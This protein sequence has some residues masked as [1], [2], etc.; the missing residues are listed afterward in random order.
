M[1]VVGSSPGRPMRRGKRPHS[2]QASADRLQ[3]SPPTDRQLG[4]PGGGRGQVSAVTAARAAATR[5]PPD[6]S[7]RRH[8]GQRARA[9]AGRREASEPEEN[10][11]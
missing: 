1:A 5:W 2:A 7:P 3:G 6:L 11:P 9:T 10:D 4:V 8:G